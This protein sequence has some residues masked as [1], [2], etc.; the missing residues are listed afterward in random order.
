MFLFTTPPARDPAPAN[1]IVDAIRQGAERTGV[2]FDYLLTTAQKESALD[3]KVR[4]G[5]S[6]ATGLFQFIEQTWLG[7]VKADG[8][9]HGLADYANAISARLDGSLA[10]PDPKLRQQILGLREN[11]RVAAVMAAI[12]N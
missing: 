6:S 5:S 3:P 4:A 11:P 10:V 9:K 1:P 12:L 8:P 2:G 7:L